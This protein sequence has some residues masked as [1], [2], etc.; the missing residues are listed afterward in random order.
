[1]EKTEALRRDLLAQFYRRN[2]ISLTIAI[3]SALLD[4]TLNLIVSWIMQQLIDTISGEAGALPLNTIA[5]CCAGLAVLVVVTSMI[6]YCVVPRFIRR[7]LVQ[8]KNFAFRKMLEKSAAAFRSE[9]SA[10][11][12]SALANDVTTLETE[13]LAKRITLIV[14]M[15]NFVGALV[16]ML[17]YSPLLTAIAVGL[18]ALPL[19]ASLLTGGK[20]KR[21]ER[22]V[23]DGN[24]KYTASLKDCLGGFDVVKSFHAEQEMQAQY[25]AENASLEQAKFTRRRVGSLINLLGAL[26]G[27]IAQIGVFLAGGYLAAGGYALTPGIVLVFTNLMNFLIQPVTELPT[28]LAGQKS[29]RALTE[30]LAQLLLAGEEAV[31]GGETA[32]LR[33]EIALRD[34]SFGYEKDHE[35]L[36]GVSAVFEQGKSYAIV[37]GSGSGKSTLL[38]VLMG[39]LPGYTGAVCYDGTELREL[40]AESLIALSSVIQQNVFVFDASVRDNITMF[41][42]FPQEQ[43]DEAIRRAHLTELIAQRG[44]DF[45]CGENGRNLSGGEKQRISIARSLLKNSALLCVDEATAALDAQTAHQVSEDILSLHGVTR[46]VVTH[47]M[48]GGILQQFDGILALKDGKIAECGTFDE[49]LARKGY[50]YALYTVSQ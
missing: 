15:V 46:I 11:Y 43:V 44:E 45:R 33:Q 20:M 50:F 7:A 39:G 37:G 47:A 10:A 41:R 22:R 35:I 9:N 18:M 19:A 25:G 3:F 5:L 40:S 29:A 21:I 34:V 8:Y 24:A 4:G 49:L 36:H 17:C 6:N 26:T 1:M 12:L 31:R 14:M 16:M 28:I 13:Y 2:H 48:D 23:S 30:K 42:E 38:N 32:A 27:Y